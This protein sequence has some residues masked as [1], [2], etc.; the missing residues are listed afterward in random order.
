MLNLIYGPPASGKTFFSDQMLI[1]ELNSGKKVTLLVPEQEAIEAEN[2][3]YDKAASE[4][5]TTEKLTVVSFRRLANLAFRRYGGIEY[6]NIGD[7]GRLIIL[8]RIIHTFMPQLK[9]YKNNLDRSF[10][11]L[12][13]SVCSELKRYSV[14]P[15][16]LSKASEKSKNE[17]LRDKLSD[18]ALIYTAYL[19]ELSSANTDA[20][21]DVNR[22]A[23]I[24]EEHQPDK[25]E[26]FFLDSFNGFTSAELRVLRSLIRFCE[27]TVTVNRPSQK[28]KTG[29]MTVEK[30]EKQLYDIAKNAK[31]DVSIVKVLDDKS[32]AKSND[33]ELIRDK[34]FD[35][36]FKS[37][38]E[39]SSDAVTLVCA[40]DAFSQAEFI[41]AKI[42]ELVR[43]GARYRDI[44]V[45]TRGADRLEG[46][47]DVV[48][49]KYGIPVFLSKR[50]KL[51]SS[52][53]Y[54]SVALALEIISERYRTEDI[55]AYIKSEISG[56]TLEEI[57]LIESYVS[58]WSIDGLRWIDQ[59]DW[60]L[61]PLGFTDVQT[62]NSVAELQLI[63]SIRNRIISPITALADD[64]KNVTAENACKAIYGFISRCGIAD[65]YKSSNDASD[66]T[67]YNTFVSML[68][69]LAK[70]GEDMF[71]DA[72]ELSSI[73][74]LMAK[75]TDY[76]K[77][78]QT[79][80]RVIAGEASLIRVNAI[81]HVFLCDC[82]NGV[83]PASVTDDSFFSD[84]EKQFLSDNGIELSPMVK[85]KNDLEAFY[86]LRAA[87]GAT[88]T[89]CASFCQKGGNEYPSIGFKRLCSLFPKNNIT[90]YPSS[91]LSIESIQN[92]KTFVD[93]LR[94]LKNTKYYDAALSVANELDLQIPSSNT[95]ITEP[96]VIISK[97][98][99]DEIFGG[100]IS[101]SHTRFESYV[102]CPFSYFCRY[103]LGIKEKKHDFFLASDMGVHIHR[104]LEKAVSELFDFEDINALTDDD[105]EK[106]INKAIGEI[107]AI[108]LG[109]DT[110]AEGKR[111]EAL[112][113]RLK[114]TVRVLI[115][116]IVNEFKNSD[117]R[118]RFFE[119]DIKNKSGCVS[120][121]KVG[122]SDG[123]QMSIRGVIDRV[124]TYEKDGKLY[125]RV[126]DYKSGTREHSLANVSYGLDTQMLLYL[127][128]IWK[129]DE[130]EKQRLFNTSSEVYPAGVLYQSARLPVTSVKAPINGEESVANAEKKLIRH[131]VLLDDKDVLFAME[132]GLE[133]RFIPV[134]SEDGELKAPKD[135]L[136]STEGFDEL[137]DVIQQVLIEQGNKMK[138]GEASA[139]PLKHKAADPCKYC[140]MYP[141]CRNKNSEGESDG[142]N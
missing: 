142:G 13:L 60:V 127:F 3:I 138:S 119:L 29:F 18:I 51:N 19:A 33:F 120:P 130:K 67:A 73:L 61:N 80:D 141:I 40:S 36:A 133:G 62:E 42:C 70:T 135:T 31:A 99:A 104:I 131:G 112:L 81:K 32:G 83:F 107:I 92:K 45:I 89:L 126:V 140:K 96:N 128:S 22:L 9:V 101:V 111:F 4:G 48:F 39:H 102:K 90:Y 43:L 38:G 52:A 59:N 2:R 12:M 41:A 35:Y 57:D 74:Y 34:L 10:I 76:G 1:K 64:L 16:D 87:G 69:T 91:A 72:K 6:G 122:L 54:K 71:F 134:K 136:I 123:T 118:P 21:D 66:I 77:L 44:A 55:M 121:L 11:E 95:A 109:N 53:L 117:F 84:T 56:F 88:E 14:L 139:Y 125:V 8:Y 93:S 116:N 58:L 137:L 7:S 108:I 85:E 47:L 114:R 94:S 105:L 65:Y 124:D 63:N 103:V 86:F 25:D 82:E 113:L 79:F 49:E 30:T 106:A 100:D 115:K 20:T 129:S 78:P 23:E 27:V 110:T 50:E 28:G 132:K 97:E 98:N 37:D 15:S 5:V 17:H 46:V 26:V 75:N 68:E 24:Y